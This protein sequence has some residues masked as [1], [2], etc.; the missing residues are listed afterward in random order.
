MW[1]DVTTITLDEKP[2]YLLAVDEERVAV[3]TYELQESGEK[4]FLLFFF[5]INS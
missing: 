1:K 4:R 5:Q 3:C 2:D